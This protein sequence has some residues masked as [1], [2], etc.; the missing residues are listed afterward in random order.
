MQNS[1]LVKNFHVNRA[2]KFG[3]SLFLAISAF[4]LSNCERTIDYSLI[5]Y[6]CMRKCFQPLHR[7]EKNPLSI[8]FLSL[9][10][11]C[12]RSKCTGVRESFR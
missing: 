4:D 10:T 5:R 1:D 11:E 8:S 2:K 3:K 7:E 9:F 12:Q 6:K